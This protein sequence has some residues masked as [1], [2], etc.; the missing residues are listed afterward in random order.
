M[1]YASK[2]QEKYFN[3]NRKKLEKKGVNVTEW[4]KASKGK[5]LPKRKKKKKWFKKADK[6]QTSRSITFLSVTQR[7]NVET[8]LVLRRNN[9]RV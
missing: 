7:Q 1:P 4:N 8:S 9:T 2:A 3:A 6:E 5:K